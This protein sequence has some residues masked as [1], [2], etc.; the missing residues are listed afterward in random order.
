MGGSSSLSPVRQEAMRGGGP[1]QVEDEVICAHTCPSGAGT[2]SGD[3]QSLHTEKSQIWG[4]PG[5][6]PCHLQAS[7]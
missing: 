7:Q 4:P 6:P 3:T 1:W 5:F 2:S